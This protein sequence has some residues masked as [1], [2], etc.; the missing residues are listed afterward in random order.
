MWYYKRI[1]QILHSIIRKILTIVDPKIMS[2]LNKHQL[3]V[4]NVELTLCS[5]YLTAV[6]FSFTKSSN[7]RVFK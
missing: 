7:W 2:P 1:F 3:H 4:L 6:I 5:V